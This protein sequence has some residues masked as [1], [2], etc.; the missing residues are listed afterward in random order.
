MNRNVAPRMPETFEAFAARLRRALAD[1]DTEVRFGLYHFSHA[2]CVE[3]GAFRVRA[4]EV[5]K[6][7]GDAYLAEHGMFMPEHAEAI[8]RPRTVVLEASSVEEI[9][10][11]LAGW[12]RTFR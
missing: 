8:S 1:G 12:E 11:Q 4:L 9:L 5:S 10:G 2:V 3:E 6:E 7:E